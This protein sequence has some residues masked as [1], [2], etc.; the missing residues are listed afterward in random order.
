[1]PRTGSDRGRWRQARCLERSG[2]PEDEVSEVGIG[3]SSEQGRDDARQEVHAG[4]GARVVGS[5]GLVC[6]EA[7]SFVTPLAL[8]RGVQV[9]ASEPSR[10]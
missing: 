9:P 2:R 1:M 6:R 8:P 10:R 3:T 7:S 4:H 5:S